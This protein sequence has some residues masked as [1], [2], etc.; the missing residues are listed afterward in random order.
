MAYIYKITNNITKKVYIGKTLYTIEHRWNQHCYN[1]K[2]DSYKN[3]PLYKSMNK[4]GIENFSVC[5][6]EEVFDEQI[7]SER[8]KFWIQYYDSY[9]NGYNATLGGDGSLLYDYDKIWELWEKGLT[10][11]EISQQI[12][13][14]DFVVRTVLSLHQISTEERK[15][16]SQSKLEQSHNPYRRKIYQIDPKT[17]E[18][19]AEYESLTAAAK[20]VSCHS[21][22]LSRACKNQKLWRGFYW[23]YVNHEYIKKDF[24]PKAVCKLDLTTGK[25]LEIYPSGAAAARAVNGD[26]SYISKVC[27]GIQKSSKGFGWCFLKDLDKIRRT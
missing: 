12:Q 6:I 19:I 14:N 27:R 3:I 25:V 11:K 15:Q 18:I 16:R 10:I 1:S 17:Q 4:Y 23:K 24:S 7:L 2:K 9:K 13:C 5:E 20:A 21:T 26:S 22:D 8:E